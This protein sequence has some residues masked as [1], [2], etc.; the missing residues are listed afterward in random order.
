MEVEVNASV[1]YWNWNGGDAPYG[2]FRANP[3]GSDFKAVIT[4]GDTSWIG[5]RVDDT[6]VY[7]WHLGALIRNLK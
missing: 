7:Y 6:A 4:S 3:D 2:I 5:L 1:V